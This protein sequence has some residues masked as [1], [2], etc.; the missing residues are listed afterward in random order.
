[1]LTAELVAHYF[2]KL[3]E[4]HNYSPAHN[5]VQK[6]YNWSTLNQKVR[7]FSTL[8]PAWRP[9]CCSHRLPPRCA[10]PALPLEHLARSTPCLFSFSPAGVQ[11]HGVCAGS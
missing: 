1:M 9:T 11:A 2:P 8:L 10:V 4:L 7:K 6:M 3:V 5:S